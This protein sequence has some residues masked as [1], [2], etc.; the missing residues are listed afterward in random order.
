[1]VGG[2]VLA[3][4]A[5]AA[6]RAAAKGAVA[7][8]CVG[9]TNLAFQDRRI[10][11]FGLLEAALGALGRRASMPASLVVFPMVA[12]ALAMLLMGCDSRRFRRQSPDGRRRLR[13]SWA[14]DWDPPATSRP[15]ELPGQRSLGATFFLLCGFTQAVH[16]HAFSTE[17]PTGAGVIMATSPRTLGSRSR[18]TTGVWTW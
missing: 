18:S 5:R 1:M 13:P 6:G 11:G 2:I 8:T 14:I 17:S 7:R 3:I 15:E 12:V 10:L 9:R 4:S 16:L